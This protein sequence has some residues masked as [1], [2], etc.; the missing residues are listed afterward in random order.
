MYKIYKS[1]LNFKTPNENG[2][3]LDFRKMRQDIVYALIAFNKQFKGQ[4][5]IKLISINEKTISLLLKIEKLGNFSARELT[6]FSKRL[7]HDRN[8]KVYSRDATKLFTSSVFQDVTNDYIEQFDIMPEINDETPKL[9]S[10]V[11]LEYD[12]ITLSD[13]DALKALDAL[14]KLQDIGSHETISLRKETLKS[15]KELLIRTL[16]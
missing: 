3:L 16:R 12:S 4:K 2:L 14:I 6:Y 5:T 11:P 8:W 13:E 9:T 10:D 7:H 15:I 1:E